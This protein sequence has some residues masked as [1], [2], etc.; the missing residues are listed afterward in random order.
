MR[1]RSTR[2]LNVG[3]QVAWALLVVLLPIS[4]LPLLQKVVRSETVAPASVVPLIWLVLIWFIPYVVCGGR[5]SRLTLPVIGLVTVAVIASAAAFFIDIPPFRNISILSRE[6]SA[7]ITLGIGVAFYMIAATYPNTTARLRLTLQLVNVSG[8]VML[9]WVFVQAY[10]WYRYGRYPT[11]MDLI[12]RKISLHVLYAQR[13]TGMAYEPSWLAHQLNM[14]YLPLWLAATIQRTSAHRFR[15]LGISLENVLLVMGAAGLFLSFSRVGLLAFLL[16]VAFVVL[17][18]NLHLAGWIQRSI[19]QRFNIRPQ[20]RAWFNTGVIVI[21]LIL[22]VIVYAGAAFGVVKFASRYD[23]R[24]AHLFTITPDLGNI[25]AYANQLAFAE[26][27][28]Y[29]AVGWGV[30]N[31]HP[32]LGVGLGNAGYFF[33]QKLPA[34]GW[35]LTEINWIL[36]RAS[37]IPNTKSL[38]TRLLAETGIVGFAFWLGWLYLLWAGARFLR[39]LREPV[40]RTLGLAGALALICLLIEGFSLDS[41]ALPYLW[42]TFGLISAASSLAYRQEAD[43]EKSLRV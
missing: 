3:S 30:F 22:F 13:A 43:A 27:L 32:I 5:L 14:V 26:R 2:W 6:I 20:I 39:A 31:D 15:I 4:S 21:L 1:A 7:F 24:L 23:Q 37:I 17:R 9:L 36:S 29:W 16:A 41:F 40:F 25:V 8:F 10:V 35:S 28:V 33:R 42:F 34:L 19:V 11:V 12:Q 18:A 38:W